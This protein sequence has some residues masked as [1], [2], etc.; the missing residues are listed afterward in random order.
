MKHICFV[1]FVLVPMLFSPVAYADGNVSDGLPLSVEGGFNNDTFAF[2]ARRH[3]VS[4]SLDRNKELFVGVDSVYLN[5]DDDRKSLIA[6]ADLGIPIK[7][8]KGYAFKAEV[9]LS[10]CG[11]KDWKQSIDSQ[12]VQL[13]FGSEFGLFPKS[14]ISVLRDLSIHAGFGYFPGVVLDD[15]D[16]VV[17]LKTGVSYEFAE[18]FYLDVSYLLARARKPDD[19]KNYRMHE[20]LLG[21]AGVKFVF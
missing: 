12:G 2:V 4:P 14:E 3:I 6:C 9:G 11:I 15:L 10:L 5:N 19:G 18:N 20:G 16:K 8:K 1:L 21:G 13:F 17:R 7:V